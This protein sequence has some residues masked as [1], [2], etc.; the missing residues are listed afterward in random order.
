VTLRMFWLPLSLTLALSACDKD[1]GETGE[2]GTEVDPDTDTDTDIDTEDDTEPGADDVF[3]DTPLPATDGLCDISGDPATASHLLLQGTVLGDNV[4][5]DGGVLIERGENGLITCTGCDCAD[6]APEDTLIV[7]CP[8]GVISP[9]LINSHDHIRYAHNRPVNL[10]SDERF[11]HRHDWREGRRGHTEI[12]AGGSRSTRENVLYGETRMLLAGATSIA[13]SISGVDSAGLLRNLD[14]NSDNE[15]LRSGRTQYATFPLSDISGRLIASGCS[16]YD[17][18]SANVLNNDSYLPHIAEGIDAEANNEFRCLSSGANGGSDVIASNTAVV[19][20]IGMTPSDISI[21]AGEGAQLVWSPRSNISLYGMTASVT[22]Y[23]TAGVRIALGTDW[24]PSGSAHLLRELQCADEMDT[25]HY[26]DFFTDREQWAMVTENAAI[27]MGAEQALGRLAEGF[28]GDITI[29]DGSVNDRYRAVI[30]ANTEDVLAVF[31]GSEILSGNSDIVGALLTS[32]DSALCDTLDVC[33]SE[34]SVCSDLDAGITIGELQSA[35]GGSAYPLF[36]CGTP[37]GEPT[38]EPLRNDEDGDGVI[39]PLV[40]VMDTDGDGIA[41]AQDNCANIFNPP[42]PLEGFVQGDFDADGLGDDCDPCP[43]NPGSVCEQVDPF[44][45]DGDGTDNTTD[46]CPSLPNADQLD[47]DG[48]GIGAACDP[49]DDFASE[50]GA[51]GAEVY[52]VKNG[53]VTGTVVLAD[54]LVIGTYEAG[55][56]F[57]LD[58]NTA[59]IDY[60]GVENSGIYAYMPDFSPRP[61]VGDQ[62]TI[63]GTVAEFFGQI[64]LSDIA[65]IE[66]TATDRNLPAYTVL[67]PA[68]ANTAEAGVNESTRV[69]I[70]GATVTA[71]NPEPGGGDSAPTNQFVLDGEIRVDDHSYLAD[72][73]PS[74]GETFSVVRGVMRWGNGQSQLL[75]QGIEDIIAGDASLDGITEDDAAVE[76]GDSTVLTV[77]LTRE[78]TDDVTVL[79]SC[80]PSQTI[81]CP[82]TVTIAGGQRS[83]DITVAGLL[84]S[85]TPATVTAEIAGESDPASVRVYN[86]L[87]ARNLSSLTAANNTV[88]PGAEVDVTLVLDIPAG[89]TTSVPMTYSGPLTGPDNVA[90][91]QGSR[92]ATFTVTAGDAPG[93]ASVS[94]DLGAEATA[95]ITVASVTVDPNL[96]FSRYIEGSGAGNKVVEITNATGGDVDASRCT[97]DLYRNGNATVDSSFDLTALTLA[98]GDEFVLCNS[99]FT[100]AASCDQTGNLNFNGDDGLA[101][102]CDGNIVDFIGSTTGGDP[103]SEWA[104]NG[105]STANQTLVRKCTVI[106]GDIDPVDAFD[107]S[108]EW[109][110]LAQDNVD[111]LGNYTCP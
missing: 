46:N 111:N 21:M 13:G 41:D 20:G 102:V 40:D 70:V 74:V 58:P 62:V 52:D 72:P 44:D 4:I 84:A 68:E 11:D 22:Q 83:A 57:Q 96:Y 50:G 75:P 3:C 30:D 32:Q 63:E 6:E 71:I 55:V 103:G 86:D 49:C 24:T 33:G 79:V 31:R 51:C 77:S 94:G 37:P 36:F 12:S 64:Q 38:C 16:D 89:A 9:G 39:F 98:N 48:D 90:V 107:P 80:T 67:T 23:A 42:R 73:F 92:M 5:Y 66:V 87:S 101:L 53:T 78:T 35:A 91:A 8:D 99:S 47:A 10:N 104:A 85:D 93:A 43:L 34:K 59:T 88:L 109:D 54:M 15:G 27:A 100:P 60:S 7:T 95:N 69:Q 29:F 18:D 61:N 25:T 1:T 82:A 65:T 97:V 106:Q 28:V 19:H 26:G 45:I 56:F 14:S 110:S 81:S 17:M 108:A 76:Q 2:T 105:V